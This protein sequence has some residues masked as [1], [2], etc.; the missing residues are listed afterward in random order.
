MR[1]FSKVGKKLRN[2]QDRHS[3]YEQPQAQTNLGNADRRAIPRIERR[4]LIAMHDMICARITTK[5][6]GLQKTIDAKTKAIEERKT[7]AKNQDQRATVG[8]LDSSNWLNQTWHDQRYYRAREAGV[9][10]PVTWRKEKGRRRATLFRQ[11]GVAERAQQRRD[12]E[13]QWKAEHMSGKRKYSDHQE[14]DDGMNIGYEGIETEVGG[15]VAQ[16]GGKD[17]GER[18]YIRSTRA[19]P[20]KR[21]KT[22]SW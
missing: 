22:K 9:T 7:D 2:P 16:T 10:H 6:D 13:D 3:E 18:K 19:T 17:V 14:A 21:K 15:L 8:K 4:N 20:K 1:I 12:L 11:R 5:S